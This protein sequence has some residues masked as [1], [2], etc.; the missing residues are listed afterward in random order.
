VGSDPVAAGQRA[1]DQPH[2]LLGQNGLY[3]QL[4]VF[5][6][7]KDAYEALPDDL[8]A[9]IDANSGIETAA[10]FGR[11]MDEGDATASSIAEELGNNIIT[12]DEEETQRWMDTASPLID[13]WIEEM[14]AQ[15]LDAAMLVDE[16]RAMIEKHA[17]GN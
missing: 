3:T 2:R 9:V 5:A 11:V 14:T 10:M 15:G 8:K 4:F 13:S 16:A 1:R 17:N 6:M 7:N 12:L